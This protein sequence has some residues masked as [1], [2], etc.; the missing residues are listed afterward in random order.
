MC[1]IIIFR[2]NTQN[3]IFIHLKAKY[4]VFEVTQAS[5]II[6]VPKLIPWWRH[7]M[8]TFSASFV[9]KIHWSSVNSPHKG[10]WHSALMFSLI[11]AWINGWVNNREAGD[12]RRHRAHDDIIVMPF[13]GH[14]WQQHP[15]SRPAPIKSRNNDQSPS[16][17][18]KNE[19]Y[20]VNVAA[21]DR[22]HRTHTDPEGVGFQR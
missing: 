8:E 12:L 13:S 20:E 11:C 3:I 17:Q 15:G 4:H 9:Q 16:G 5:N 14:L 6:W 7:Q 1:M 10:Q 2:R 18:I 19:T 21:P 22:R